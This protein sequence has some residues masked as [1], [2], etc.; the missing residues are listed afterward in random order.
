MKRC[1]L[2]GF[3]ELSAIFVALGQILFGGH[4]FY[5]KGLFRNPELQPLHPHG[6]L[7]H[8]FGLAGGAEPEDPV[9]VL[10][11]GSASYCRNFRPLGGEALS[12]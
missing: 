3:G 8:A 9:L 11:E 10:L 6:F 1:R 2:Q 7:L 5:A 4:Y 12:P